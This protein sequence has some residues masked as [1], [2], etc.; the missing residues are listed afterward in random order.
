MDQQLVD[1]NLATRPGI[2]VRTHALISIQDPRRPM[3]AIPESRLPRSFFALASS[4]R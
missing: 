1:Q 4:E 2:A 3:A